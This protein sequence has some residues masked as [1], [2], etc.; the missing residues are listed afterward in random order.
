MRRA[1]EVSRQPGS[2]RRL[3]VA[4]LVN[5][6]PQAGAD[7]E[8]T[9]TPRSEAEL[10]TLRELVDSFAA[11]PEARMWISMLRVVFL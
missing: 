8:T 6:V 1:S 7:G 11:L 10:Q 2:T 4:V 5:G 3:T 9:L